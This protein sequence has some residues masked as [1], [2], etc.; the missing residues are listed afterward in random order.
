MTL[1]EI[2]SRLG[3]GSKGAKG[4]ARARIFDGFEIVDRH[5]RSQRAA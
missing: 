1:A 2:G 3:A 5:W 4:E